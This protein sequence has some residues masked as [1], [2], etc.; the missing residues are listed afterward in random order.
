MMVNSF[1]KLLKI[2]QKISRAGRFPVSLA[3]GSEQVSLPHLHFN[4]SFVKPCSLHFFTLFPPWRPNQ[5]G[6]EK[7]CTT[8]KVLIY[9]PGKDKSLNVHGSDK[10][11]LNVEVG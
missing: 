1:T 3:F 8:S 7:V 9:M 4:D 2:N 11:A 6:S 5:E 10:Q